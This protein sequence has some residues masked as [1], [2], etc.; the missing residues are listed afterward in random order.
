MM[1]LKITINAKVRNYEKF[2]RQCQ[3]MMSLRWFLFEFSTFENPKKWGNRWGKCEVPHMAYFHWLKEERRR[4]EIRGEM[5]GKG[6]KVLKDDTKRDEG[7]SSLRVEGCSSR[8]I[9]GCSSWRI[10]WC[11]SWRIEGWLPKDEYN[12]S[13]PINMRQLFILRENPRILK[14][15]ILFIY[16]F[17]WDFERFLGVIVFLI[18]LACNKEKDYCLY[19]FS[20]STYI[21]K[22]MKLSLWMHD[23]KLYQ[24]CMPSVCGANIISAIC[25]R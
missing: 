6:I 3:S 8:R 15:R 17:L 23:L 24:T 4:R 18:R 2:G 25:H 7:C 21:S 16:F 13:F 12:F 22:C 9:E 10:E 14:E 20:T 11:S 5:E 1:A 19:F